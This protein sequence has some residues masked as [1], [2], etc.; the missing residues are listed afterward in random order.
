MV[1][2]SHFRQKN[3]LSRIGRVFRQIFRKKTSKSYLESGVYVICAYDDGKNV[4]SSID[5]KARLLEFKNLKSS[6]NLNW[7]FEGLNFEEL[8]IKFRPAREVRPLSDSVEDVE[9]DSA[10]HILS[11]NLC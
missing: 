8:M 2:I 3:I 4:A 7:N 5:V 1:P 6:A 9:T 11:L 10:P